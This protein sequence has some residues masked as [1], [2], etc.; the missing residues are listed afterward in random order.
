MQLL[1]KV[2]IAPLILMVRLYQWLISPLF[3]PSCRYTPTCSAY[4]VEAL[5]IWGP[6][7]GTYLGLKRIGS[8]HPRGGFGYDPVPKRDPEAPCAAAT[9]VLRHRA[10]SVGLSSFLRK[11]T[12]PKVYW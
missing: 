1:K 10:H 5:Q 9:S 12:I 6:F 4:M 8:C 3:P 11:Q 2:L 7:K